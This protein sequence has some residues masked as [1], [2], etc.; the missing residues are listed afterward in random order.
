MAERVSLSEFPSVTL[1]KNKL[2][3]VFEKTESKPQVSDPKQGVFL[4]F[5]AEES[6]HFILL[7]NPELASLKSFH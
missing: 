7:K 4:E 6:T 5:E 2:F 1:N 3:L